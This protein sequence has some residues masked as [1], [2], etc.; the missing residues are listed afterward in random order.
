MAQ[1]SHMTAAMDAEEEK[2][3]MDE[4]RMSELISEAKNLY[5]WMK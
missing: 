1:W 5:D 2:G 4:D 3:V